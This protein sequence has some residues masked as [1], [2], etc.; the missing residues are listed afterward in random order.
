MLLMQ[1]GEGIT[2]ALREPMSGELVFGANV[3]ITLQ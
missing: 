3:L 1:P 2:D